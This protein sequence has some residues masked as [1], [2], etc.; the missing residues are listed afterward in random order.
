MTRARLKHTQ[1]AFIAY[2]SAA[3]LQP[4]CNTIFAFEC[5]WQQPFG[6]VLVE[7]CHSEAPT[8]I[9][10]SSRWPVHQIY[11]INCY[12][13]FLSALLHNVDGT[14]NDSVEDEVS[15]SDSRQAS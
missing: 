2:F 14:R 12:L 10:R 13:L 8:L 4:N 1:A 15:N 6:Q 7:L 3:P 11:G 5:R 9:R